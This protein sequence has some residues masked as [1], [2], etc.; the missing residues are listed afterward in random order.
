[1]TLSFDKYQATGNDFVMI[2]NR[3]GIFPKD[4]HLL[5]ARLCDRKFGL[6]ADGLILIEEANEAN[7]S[8]LYFNAD[9]APGSF[10]G[11]GSRAAT[12]FA[13]SLGMISGQGSLQAFDGQHTAEIDRNLIKVSMANVQNG[14]KV[15]NGTFIDTGSPHYV[16]IR[17]DL[18]IMDVFTEGKKLREDDQFKPGGSNINFIKIKNKSHIKVRTFERGVENE[19]LSCGTGV[20]A[21]AMIATKEKGPHTIKVETLGGVLEIKFDRTAAGFENVFLTGPAERVFSGKIEI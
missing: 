10:C 5:I 17:D 19:T 13:E 1:M 14:S 4:N 20:T 6:G 8:M 16:E 11:N 2:D 9:G 3:K 18:E 12:R 15:L 21:A 7:Y